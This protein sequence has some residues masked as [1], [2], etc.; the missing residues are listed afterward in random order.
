MPFATS[1]PAFADAEPIWSD[2]K[3][4]FLEANGRVVD[5]LQGN[6]SH[7]EG[8]GYGLLLAQAFG[9]RD[10]FDAIESWTRG[11]LLIRDD[12]LMAWRW[13][14]E[15]ADPATADNRDWHT[16]TDGDLFRAWGLLRADTFSGWGDYGAEVRR[17]AEALAALCLKPDPRAP[18]EVVLTPGAEALGTPDRVLFNPSYVMPRALRELGAYSGV[19]E[20]I[21]AADH[22]ET[23]L[24]E[25][26]ATGLVPDWSMITPTGF[27]QPEGFGTNHGYDAIR[28]A[29]YLHW[30][31]QK[32]HPA[33]TQKAGVWS[34]APALPVV[35][36]P[37][38]QV[39]E[40]STFPG[41]HAIA[42]LI[43]C[44][45]VAPHPDQGE[46]YY[47]ATLGLL[48]RVARRESGLCPA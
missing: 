26:A 9:D 37:E 25:L 34:G 13:R 47:P 40:R 43:A 31:G 14:P 8:Q 42:D 5:S 18:G 10:A 44:R 7:S 6:A 15:E 45:P 12:T 17:I 2:W 38:G 27:A 28:V 23:I 39:I 20:L 22:G 16:A 32:T 35:L 36:T 33:L 46:P 24:A 30:S 3:A 19:T 21:R 29:L 48:S 11:H 1:R 41:Y 4:R